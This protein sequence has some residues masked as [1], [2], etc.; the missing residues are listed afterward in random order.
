M[1]KFQRAMQLAE[2]NAMNNKPTNPNTTFELLNFIENLKDMRNELI[3]ERD[4]SFEDYRAGIYYSLKIVD[5]YLKDI[6]EEG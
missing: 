6:L 5:K 3:E 1:T 2:K 4:H